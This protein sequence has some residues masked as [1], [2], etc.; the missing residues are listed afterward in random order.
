MSRFA[1][2]NFSHLTD[3]DLKHVYEPAEDSFLLLDAIENDYE[4]L[5]KQEPSIC[6][7]VGS[8][9]GVCIT[10][11]ARVLGESAVYWSTDI[12]PVA[13]R[14]TRKTAE[15]NNVQVE[16]VITDLVK[17]L[18]PRLYKSVDVLL[19]NPP[20]VVTPPEEVGSNSIEAS[21]AGGTD[22]RQVMNRLFPKVKDILS[23]KGVFYLVIVKENNQDDIE[24]IMLNE[25]FK[26]ENIITRRTGPELLSVLK[27]TRLAR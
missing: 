27:F 9:S 8:G 10:F 5:R 1:T 15:S 2:P 18:L 13:A 6:V 22:G 16:P 20:Y 25:G 24:K 19:F 11:L 26:M 3:E 12:N 7:E 23:P 21:W 17:G 4:Y 14:V